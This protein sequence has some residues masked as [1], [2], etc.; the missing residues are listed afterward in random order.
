MQ[1]QGQQ[2]RVSASLNAMP[3]ASYLPHPSYRLGKM[4]TET[5]RKETQRTE[6]KRDRGKDKEA[7]PPRHTQRHR[8]RPVVQTDC[9]DRQ[10]AHTDKETL[11]VFQFH[12]W[13]GL[14]ELPV[15][16]VHD[17]HPRLYP[18]NRCLEGV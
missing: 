7:Q 8:Q 5:E 15:H 1:G 13:R 9:V 17:A 11:L 2:P 16:G 12:P 18:E 4:K 6:T 10:E 3:W 14:I